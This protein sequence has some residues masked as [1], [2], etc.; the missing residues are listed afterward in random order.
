MHRVSAAGK[1]Q[2]NDEIKKPRGSIDDILGAIGLL[3]LVGWV[4]L[5]CN[6]HTSAF[7]RIVAAVGGEED[8]ASCTAQLRN[9]RMTGSIR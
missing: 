2:G 4:G 8:H 3:L 1:R 7:L 6:V 9:D 5:F